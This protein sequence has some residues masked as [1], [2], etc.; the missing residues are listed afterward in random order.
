VLVDKD[1]ADAL[2]DDERFRLRRMRRTAV[3]GYRHLEPWKLRRADD[4]G[5]EEQ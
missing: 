4:Q 5:A 3:K 2:H 1:L